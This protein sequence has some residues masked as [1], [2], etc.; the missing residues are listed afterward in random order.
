MLSREE[1][2]KRVTVLGQYLSPERGR[3][4]ALLVFSCLKGALSAEDAQGIYELLPE[5]VRYLWKEAPSS[6]GSDNTD[7]I[8]LAKKVGD[9][10]YRAAAER[11]FEVIFAS[12]GEI[13][14]G[15]TKDRLIGRLPSQ[16]KVIFERSRACVLDG[17][18]GD[19]L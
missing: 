6:G 13:I 1:Y 19:F 17:S 3:A 18:P 12:I 7:C 9:Y 2:I 14:D 5:P 4:T 10:P 8:T 16:L 15:D 11:A